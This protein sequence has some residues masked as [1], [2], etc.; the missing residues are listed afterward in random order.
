MTTLRAVLLG[1]LL[2]ATITIARS[3]FGLLRHVRR[4]QRS[5]IPYTVVPISS[6]YLLFVLF[7]PRVLNL[8]DRVLG[9]PSS[10]TSWRWLVRGSWPWRRRYAPFAHMGS[11]TFLTVT[12]SGSI[13]YTADADVI[14]QI[15]GRMADFPKP[16]FL[17]K[18]VDIFGKN[19]VTTEGAAWRRHRKLVA[20]AFGEKNNRLVWAETIRQTR[21]LLEAWS[22]G[23]AEPVK[24]AHRDCM[25]LSLNVIGKAG[26]G[27]DMGLATDVASQT[28]AIEPQDNHVMTFVDSLS[29]LLKNIFPIVILPKW[30]LSKCNLLLLLK[31]DT[32]KVDF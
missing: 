26:F 14:S 16:T 20:P 29:C 3:V 11:D 30:L 15:L 21:A 7:G 31:I 12:P 28:A 17:Y 6:Y 19:V 24:M 32:R 1:F 4:A 27:R 10:E 5:G 18:N 9:L 23:G 2:V 25:K 8:L 13:L 22:W